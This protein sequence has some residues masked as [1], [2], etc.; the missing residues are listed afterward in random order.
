ML[1][2]TVPAGIRPEVCRDFLKGS[3]F[4]D[5]C[6]YAH[7]GHETIGVAA[8]PT[9]TS[10][11][12][13]CRDFQNGRCFRGSC[14]FFHGSGGDVSTMAGG[15]ASGFGIYGYD[16]NGFDNGFAHGRLGPLAHL[17]P[18]S[19]HAL[20]RVM[21]LSNV[22][23]PPHLG[24]MGNSAPHSFGGHPHSFDAPVFAAAHGAHDPHVFLGASG[25]YP[26]DSSAEA[27]ALA[28][29]QT[30]QHGG[31]PGA[32]A[33]TLFALQSAQLRGQ[34]R[35]M[36]GVTPNNNVRFVPQAASFQ[37][38]Q[39]AAIQATQAVSANVVG[40]FVPVSRT[41]A[42]P[43]TET[44][45]T[46][47]LLAQSL[48]HVRPPRIGNGPGPNHG[49]VRSDGHITHAGNNSHTNGHGDGGQT[50]ESNDGVDIFPKMFWEAQNGRVVPPAA[51]AG[52]YREPRTATTSY[53][54]RVYAPNNAGGGTGL[55]HTDSGNLNSPSMWSLGSTQ[56]R[57]LGPP[58]DAR[59]PEASRRASF[60]GVASFG[61]ASLDGRVS[62]D[63]QL[64]SRTDGFGRNPGGLWDDK[65]HVF[66]PAAYAH[67]SRTTLDGRAS[68]E[69]I[70]PPDRG[71]TLDSVGSDGGG[72]YR[73]HVPLGAVAKQ[74]S[75]S[76]AWANS[77]PGFGKPENQT[78][79]DP[80]SRSGR[81]SY[82]LF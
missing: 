14:R 5:N 60:G 23:F 68:V 9:Q 24:A 2:A 32:A 13:V 66:A 82:S 41:A 11:Q 21:S 52:G 33:Q 36:Q 62:L 6:R 38:D 12:P 75:V 30:S 31:V 43:R 34:Q 45:V 59:E 27:A 73:E 25:F 69:T 40:G 15:G 49:H 44:T 46:S 78:Q 65:S 50:M 10:A 53:D 63:G 79:H 61:N 81:S 3:C 56:P 26:N 48:G 67:S 72:G 22:G 64:V 71:G 18:H 70:I 80:D 4:R 74:E 37:A 8:Q 19:V 42:P 57:D 17:H 28:A 35:Q 51:H 76:P 47:G 54:D 39:W 77:V 1:T 16:Q 55:A 7:S 20:A 29:T 58:R